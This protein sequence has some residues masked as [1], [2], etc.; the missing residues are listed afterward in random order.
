MGKFY[1]INSENLDLFNDTLAQTSIPQWVSI[2]LLGNN[3]QNDVYQVKKVN[4]LYETLTN[5]TNIIIII[6]EEIFDGLSDDMKNIL[7]VEMLTSIEID[8]DKDSISIKKYDFTTYSTI[9]EKF[10]ADNLV[11][12]KESIIS[13]FDQ[14]RE[15]EKEEKN[16]RKNK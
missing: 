8:Y 4:D 2:E 1:K 6:N 11:K 12:L 3:A 16:S 14:K 15:R 7:F 10:G 9:L 13:L 5:G